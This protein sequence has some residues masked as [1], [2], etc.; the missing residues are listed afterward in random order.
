MMNF[1]AKVW[2]NANWLN[3]QRNSILFSFYGLFFSFLFL[4][5]VLV[6]FV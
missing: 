1:M 2:V 5:V 6:L 4:K 3:I